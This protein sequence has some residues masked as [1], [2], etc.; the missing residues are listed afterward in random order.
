MERLFVYGTLAPNKPNEHILKDLNGTWKYSTVRGKLYQEGWGSKM[1][2][3]G[4]I[5]DDED[6]SQISG[7]LFSSEELSKKWDF[8][9]DFEGVEYERVLVKVK[10]LTG[11]YVDAYIYALKK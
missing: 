7:L 1:G 3:P 2:C 8:L 5:L 9:D 10:L 6:S 11:E 4:I